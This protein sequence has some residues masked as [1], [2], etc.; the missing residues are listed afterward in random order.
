MRLEYLMR[1]T[2][3]CSAVFVLICC[4]L[5]IN[6][7]GKRYLRAIEVFS[8][9]VQS[10][11]AA[12]PAAPRRLTNLAE[13]RIA[14]DLQLG[15]EIE[16]REVILYPR[17]GITLEFMIEQRIE[18]S[19]TVSNEGPHLDLLDWKHYL[20]PWERL[21]EVGENRYRIRDVSNEEATS[22]PAVSPEEIREAV[23][24]A[25][26]ERWAELVRDVKGP[27]DAPVL[28]GVSKI[29]LKVSVKEGGDWKVINLIEF[30]IP[31]GC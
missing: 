25:G 5:S 22:F 10:A 13:K 11:N 20:S 27:H 16:G 29:S 18:T 17:S 4:A 7:Q 28:V 12:E 3:I 8:N 31:M 23:L 15:E 6:A 26:G 14:V 30:L 24:R 21:D 1:K 2:H 9:G 19:L